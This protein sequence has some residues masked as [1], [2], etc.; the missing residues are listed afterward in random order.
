MAVPEAVIE[1]ELSRL[2][3][4]SY[5][6]YSVES[7]GNIHTPLKGIRRG[8][9]LSPLLAAFHLYEVDLY[10]EKKHPR[11]RYARYMDDFLILA[12]TR[13]SLRRAVRGLNRLM[14]EYG[15]TLHPDKTQLGYTARGFDW[16]GLWFTQGGMQS[17]AP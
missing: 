5:L 16:M 17:I 12:P 6:P 13:W 9:A 1:V 2:K 4:L 15:F 8:A 3:A 11:V 14:E 10:F 7:G